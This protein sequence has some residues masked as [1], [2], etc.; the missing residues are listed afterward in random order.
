MAK[1]ILNFYKEL[2]RSF[3]QI[4]M[5]LPSS[6]ALAKA[7]VAPI[8]NAN[9]PLRILEAGPGTGPFT[10]EILRLM[11]PDD[12]F[13]I[14]EINPRFIA[15]LKK[16]LANNPDYIRNKDRV[17]FFEGP[18]QNIGALN[19]RAKFDV[20]VSSLPFF[21]F[22]P[23]LVTEILAQFQSMLVE[24]GSLTF[25]EYLGTRQ[26]GVLFSN[27]EHRERVKGVEDVIRNW[28]KT[29]Q[30]SGKLKRRVAMLNVPPT[31]TYEYQYLN[32]SQAAS[33]VN[34]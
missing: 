21:N 31:M 3:Q 15:T 2:G 26:I 34:S 13:V 10:R 14:C 7:M 28:C 5:V 22:T 16:T 20:I 12:S 18:V 8:P 24:N 19:G 9:R 30:G 29:V 32:G 27:R 23:E 17:E 33:L 4:G 1:E 11:G 6:P 25:C